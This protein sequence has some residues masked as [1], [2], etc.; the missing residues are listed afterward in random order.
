MLWQVHAGTAMVHAAAAHPLPSPSPL[1]PSPPPQ[2]DG[3]R[4]KAIIRTDPG[5]DS[6]AYCHSFD[7]LPGEWQ[8]IRIPFTDFFPVFRAKTLKVGGWEGRRE[9]SAGRG[10]WAKLQAADSRGGV[11]A[12]CA[13]DGLQGCEG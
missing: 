9:G 10:S 12:G 7:T 1:T 3:Q 5:W 11:R 8:T 6:I 13:H 2:G 4:Y